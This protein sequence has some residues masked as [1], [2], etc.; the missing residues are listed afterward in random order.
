MNLLYESSHRKG[1]ENITEEH[2]EGMQR[3]L[4]ERF[5]MQTSVNNITVT[6]FN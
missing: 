6:Y 3:T 1:Y 5:K 4:C 2:E